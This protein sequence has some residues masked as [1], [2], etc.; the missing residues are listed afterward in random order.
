M[1]E[2]WTDAEIQ[3]HADSYRRNLHIPVAEMLTSYLTLRADWR[4]LQ[5]RL[6]TVEDL[7]TRAW[8]QTESKPA[9]G[10]MKLAQEVLQWMTE[11]EKA[12]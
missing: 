9:W 5:Q 10:D 6:K 4:K 1:A 2:T 8:K 12:R 7:A 11:M 3:A